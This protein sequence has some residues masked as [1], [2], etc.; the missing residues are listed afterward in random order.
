MGTQGTP[1]SMAMSRKYIKMA[2][3]LGCPRAPTILA[4]LIKDI[5]AS[6]PLLEQRVVLCGLKR[7]DLNGRAG[8]AKD[9]EKMPSGRYIVELDARGESS[10]TLVKL[11]PANVA[12]A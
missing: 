7:D 10:S 2:S 4:G 6:C 3:K 8:F 12:A 5:N 9:F 11:K 1:Q